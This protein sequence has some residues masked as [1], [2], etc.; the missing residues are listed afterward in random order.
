[1]SRHA[2]FRRH[3]KSRYTLLHELRLLAQGETVGKTALGG[4]LAV[5]GIV[6]SKISIYLSAWY[7]RRAGKEKERA[8]V[9][10]VFGCVCV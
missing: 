1:M 7:F 10:C 9:L 5:S 8:R 3:Y 2:S 6:S 4:Y